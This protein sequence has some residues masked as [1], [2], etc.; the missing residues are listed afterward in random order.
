MRTFLVLGL[1]A[2]TAAVALVAAVPAAAG[3]DD[4]VIRRGSCS[5]ASN[6]KLKLGLDDGKIETEFEVD[7]NRNG[8]RWRVVLKRDGNRFFRGV[9]TTQA[10]SGS[11]EV[12][13]KTKNP[14]GPNRIKARAVNLSSGEICKGAATI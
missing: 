2:L 4:D 13:R 9:R 1:T 3:G 14:A 11:F 8:Q 6:W 5:G 12:K 7:Q 10:P